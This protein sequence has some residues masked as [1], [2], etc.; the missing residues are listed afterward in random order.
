MR[1]KL[2]KGEQTKLLLLA[3]KK[4]KTESKLS[5]LISIPEGT[6]YAY[7]NEITTLPLEKFKVLIDFLNLKKEDVI[8]E[9]FL[10]NNWGRVKGGKR[11]FY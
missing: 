9:K 11:W 2:K 3:I 1:V 10:D 6:I 7:K 4:A 8:I 5:K